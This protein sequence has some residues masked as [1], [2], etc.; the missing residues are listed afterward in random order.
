M[1]KFRRQ[2][3]KEASLAR[4]RADQRV[5]T[6]KYYDGGFSTESGKAYELILKPGFCDAHGSHTIFGDTVALVR[7]RMAGIKACACKECSK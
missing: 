7:E 5:Q 3:R 4:L 6:A 2:E 1:S